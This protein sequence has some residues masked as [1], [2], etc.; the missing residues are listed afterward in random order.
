MR[1]NQTSTLN[2]QQQQFS[3]L[4]QPLYEKAPLYDVVK[5]AHPSFFTEYIVIF[6]VKTDLGHQGALLSTITVKSLF[7]KRLK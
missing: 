2:Q 1:P 4:S 7:G 3:L 5:I 6:T